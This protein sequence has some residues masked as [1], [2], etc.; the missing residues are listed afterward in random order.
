MT[1]DPRAAYDAIIA[2]LSAAGVASSKMF[3]VPC[4]KYAGKAFAVFH[5]E[6]MVFK[7]RQPEHAAALALTGAHL[8]DPGGSGR[9]M[10]E[11]V[12]VPAAH[13]ARWPDLAREALHY[14]TASL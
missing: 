14:L 1:A 12:E 11:W 4:L 13:M 2:D 7:L 8:F 6:S 3:G 5:S 9:A 10:K